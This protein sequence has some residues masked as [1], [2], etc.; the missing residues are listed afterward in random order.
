M[1]TKTGDEVVPHDVL[2][3]LGD[4]VM[5]VNVDEHF[6][7]SNRAADR[8]LG[9]SIPDAGPDAW[10]SHYGVFQ[11]DRTTPFQV[12]DYPLI[13]ALRGEET[14]NVEIF[15][16]NPGVP[17]GVLISVTG[18]PL[19]D[20][21]GTITGAS[22]VF[23]DVTALREQERALAGAHEELRRIEEGQRFFADFART[24]AATLE[25]DAVVSEIARHATRHLADACVVTLA[26]QEGD[27]RRVAVA[28][29]V[30]EHAATCAAL[31]RELE[32]DPAAEPLARL[33]AKRELRCAAFLALP[34]EV[35][36]AKVG[37]L[38]FGAC[39]P[40]RYAE[41]GA[42]L[43][44]EY[45]A[46]ASHAVERALL[47]V[48]AQRA[49]AARN[50]VLGV[51][52]HELR[53]PLTAILLEVEGMRRRAPAPER[54]SG[55]A[56]ANVCQAV[57]R[58]SRLIKDL[59]SVARIDAG[60]CSVTK[61]RTPVRALVM[62]AVAA[63]QALVAA[64]PLALSVDVPEGLPDVAADRPRVLQV[65][66]NLISNAVKFTAPGGKLALSAA[67]GDGAVEFRVAD[68]GAGVAADALPHVFD[69]FWQNEG[70]EK[71]G[72]GLGLPIAKGIVEAHGGRISVAS[73]PGRGSTFRFTLPVFVPCAEPPG[74]R[75]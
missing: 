2:D 6:V 42:V 63:Q 51:V 52:A 47:Y 11:V 53:N 61:A 70:G 66:E 26:P 67:A 9:R 34:L 39:D 17:D 59:L 72:I 75:P 19:R 7:F 57:M 43:A 56:I 13:R 49:I 55:E 37:E 14:E 4:G 40:G 16:R 23:R 5:V 33:R 50:D 20:A 10:A 74:A 48:R 44:K 3:S 8:I 71:H 22:V 41:R 46:C 60:Q 18:R 58:M 35:R 12:D 38:A 24:M 25:L 1:Y 27:A 32:G 29:C 15:V 45:A 30:E 54:R 62:E 21:S 68:S 69:R 64:R 65:F 73:E 31:A 28:A 36:G